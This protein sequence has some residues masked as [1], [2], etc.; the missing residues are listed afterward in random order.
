MARRI[1]SLQQNADWGENRPAH[2]E[3]RSKKGRNRIWKIKSEAFFKFKEKKEDL[4]LSYEDKLLLFKNR[5]YR[6]KL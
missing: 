2:R 1:K 3:H 6:I 5:R 4:K